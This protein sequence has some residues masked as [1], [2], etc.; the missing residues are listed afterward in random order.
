MI[1]NYIIIVLSL[2]V[3]GSTSAQECASGSFG[4]A[5]VPSGSFVSIFANHTFVN[6]GTG[7][8]PGTIETDRGNSPGV[9]NFTNTASWSGADDAAHVNGFV[10]TFSST[11]FV[12]PV[13]SGERLRMIGISGS[14]NATAAFVEED[15]A[16]SIG[17]MDLNNADLDAVSNRE[18]WILE[19]GNETT[20]T[21][22]WDQL[23]NVEDLV[24]GDINKLTIVGWDG[25]SWEII[26]TSVN[27]SMLAN[28]S[29]NTLNDAVSTSFSVGSMTSD[30]VITP[31]N[32]TLITL[33]SLATPRSSA[34][35]DGEISVFP[36]PALLAEDTYISY[37]LKKGNLGKIE[38]YDGQQRLVFEQDVDQDYGVIKLP[39]F[40]LTDDTYFVTLLESDGSRQSQILIMVR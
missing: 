26:P 37:N 21:L 23:S 31:N 15:P 4:N 38:V 32:F 28:N 9:V 7:L 19:G 12:F 29:T 13:G 2:L 39:T 10:R 36:N 8:M 35:E 22:T 24:G 6:G 3:L 16:V 34:V 25:D 40:N 5:F 1:R 30:N 33:G 14:E 18:Y 27:A 17:T 20:I 11:P